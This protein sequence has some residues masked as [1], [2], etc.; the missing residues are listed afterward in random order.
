MDPRLIARVQLAQAGDGQTLTQP[1]EQ[2]H[3]AVLNYAY[4]V[5]GDGQSSVCLA[6]DAFV[7][8]QQR[9]TLG[10]AQGVRPQ[11]QHCELRREN[12]LGGC[13]CARSCPIHASGMG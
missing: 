13:M 10:M 8:S 7:I 5:L 12:L 3:P 6:Q 9:R 11:Q 2:L 1:F 4:Q